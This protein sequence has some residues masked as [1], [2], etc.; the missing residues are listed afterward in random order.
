MSLQEYETIERPPPTVACHSCQHVGYFSV[1]P[2]TGFGEEDTPTCCPLCG[3]CQLLAIESLDHIVFCT[4]CHTM[5]RSSWCL[6]GH[7]TTECE[8]AMDIYYGRWFE[9]NGRIPVFSSRDEAYGFFTRWKS[10][11]FSDSDVQFV[12]GCYGKCHHVAFHCPNSATS[13]GRYLSACCDVSC[14]KHVTPPW[15]K[16]SF[17]SSYSHS[18]SE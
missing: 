14:N 1:E 7:A 17:G 2:V 11:E 9:I 8:D 13:S 5:V 12:C 18:V 3:K 6:H 10:D 16:S 4:H 15:V